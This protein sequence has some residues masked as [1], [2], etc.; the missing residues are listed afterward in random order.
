MK[1]FLTILLMFI[2][3]TLPAFSISDVSQ[4]VAMEYANQNW[5]DK[6]NDPILTG[7]VMKTANSNY[8]I[9][10]N[11]LKVL[12][13]KENVK[14]GLANELPTINFNATASREKYSGN[15]PFAGMFFPSYYVS[16]IRFPFT[17]NY[18]VDIWG[19]NRNYTKKLKKELEALEYDEKAAVI[20][21]KSLTG[22][23]YFNIMCVDKQIEIQ[24]N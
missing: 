20:S 24:K 22:S 19:K 17:V 5:W 23:V 12:E 8:D 10:I 7:Y 14:E 11:A 2:T 16:S 3:V 4:N 18:E 9:K 15:I 1:K 6:F 21:L 13:G